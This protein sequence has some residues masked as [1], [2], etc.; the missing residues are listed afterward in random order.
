MRLLMRHGA[1][2][3]PTGG[4]Y[5][6]ATS[7]GN[8]RVL[9]AATAA[10][11]SSHDIL[12]TLLNDLDDSQAATYALRASLR[13]AIAS[14]CA[15]CIELL[16]A[17]PGTKVQS[18]S[19][20][21]TGDTVSLAACA[22]A[23]GERGVL[24]L[25]KL[26]A[27]GASVE[28][29]PHEPW[30]SPVWLAV[31]KNAPNMLQL[32]LDHGA[33]TD[34]MHPESGQTL[35]QYAAQ[36]NCTRC[37]RKLVRHAFQRRSFSLPPHFGPSPMPSGAGVSV[38]CSEAR[39]A[40]GGRNS[41]S[42]S[43]HV[44]FSD[45]PP[46]VIPAPSQ[47]ASPATRKAAPGAGGSPKQAHGSSTEDNVGSTEGTTNSGTYYST[48]TSSDPVAAD[49]VGSDRYNLG[50]VERQ[51]SPRIAAWVA[52]QRRSSPARSPPRSSSPDAGFSPNFSF[53]SGSPI[54]RTRTGSGDTPLRLASWSW[55]RCTC[56]QLSH[57]T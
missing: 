41:S 21:E 11:T 22:A 37:V 30:P 3:V 9:I 13:Q 57:L 25:H 56:S 1:R 24:A 42:D 12:Q 40:D 33:S 47:D 55:V 15:S 38:A 20:V 26:L 52:P 16:A 51:D 36:R 18:T 7:R 43:V 44:K 19:L 29:S 53:S 31:L 48:Y 32:L 5:G 14:E 4:F 54:N 49:V 6:H 2:A 17:H 28:S 45:A 34:G 39:R 8:E 27:H 10:C 50:Q 46:K 35:L 23:R